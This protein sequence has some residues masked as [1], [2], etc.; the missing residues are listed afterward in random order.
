MPLL[1][2]HDPQSW[3]DVQ[4]LDRPENYG[5]VLARADFGEPPEDDDGDWVPLYEAAVEV[6]EIPVAQ[7][8]WALGHDLVRWRIVQGEQAPELEVWLQDVGALPGARL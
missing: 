4:P 8:I 7:V 1:P 5:A 2:S 3:N 6:C